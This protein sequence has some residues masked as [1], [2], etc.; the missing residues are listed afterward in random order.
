MQVDDVDEMELADTPVWRAS[1]YRCRACFVAP[2]TTIL[3][4]DEPGPGGRRRL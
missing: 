1:Q 4:V 2:R 3:L